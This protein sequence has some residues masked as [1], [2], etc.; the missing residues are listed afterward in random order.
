MA[1]ERQGREV[2]G[3]GLTGGREGVCA[4]S[5]RSVVTGAGFV[6]FVAM[7]GR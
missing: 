7:E 5:Y 1:V 4:T 2:N 6:V 3:E